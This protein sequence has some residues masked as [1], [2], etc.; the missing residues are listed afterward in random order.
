MTRV[1]GPDVL[2][3]AKV[4]A[5]VAG[6]G[7]VVV[8]V[9]V[10]GVNYRDVYERTGVTRA[11]EPPFVAG[12][13]GAGTVREL[14]PGVTELAP[15]D[16]IAWMHVP[17]SYA[18]RVVVPVAK[19]VPV[20]ADLELE[21]AAASILQGVTAHYLCTTTYQV[22][23]GDAVLVHAAAGGTGLLLTQ[24]VK[25][26]GGRVL[27]TTSSEEK[28]ELARAAGA[29]EVIGYDDFD[30]RVLELTSGEG[31]AAIFD[32]VGGPTAE[33]G[34]ACLRTRG[35]LAIFGEAGGEVPHI[36][37]RLLA[38]G[39]L[40]VTRPR[41]RDHVRSREA[42]LDRAGEIFELVRAGHLR[43][44]LAGRFPLSEAAR[45]QEELVSR[46]TSGKLLL[47]A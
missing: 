10:A 15:G 11:A 38:R 2:T 22:G 19:A 16:R 32:G 45:A 4:A 21:L 9:T 20:P 8:D 17:G 47:V 40:Y 31:V 14:G 23:A 46:R 41:S 42:L 24:L 6:R 43:I 30:Q 39:S 37:T 12:I 13:E 25:L 35:V 34:L 44:R 7:E 27:A 18:E 28:A 5:P 33:R 1:G 29:D 3:W 26:R 36:D